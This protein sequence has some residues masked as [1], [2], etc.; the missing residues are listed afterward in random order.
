MGTYFLGSPCPIPTMPSPYSTHPHHAIPISTPTFQKKKKRERWPLMRC[1]PVQDVTQSCYM[2]YDRGGTT[3]CDANSI[4]N[5]MVWPMQ[6][7]TGNT[8]TNPYHPPSCN[9]L[10][11]CGGVLCHPPPPHCTMLPAVLYHLPPLYCA[12]LHTWHAS[13]FLH[14]VPSPST[15]IL[16]YPSRS[17]IILPSMLP[18]QM[19]FS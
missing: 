12:I 11:Q 6:R 5:R 14:T 15:P 1:E 8:Y 9:I 13:F 7:W 16:C 17:C 3:L 2:V 19:S 10:P 18:S 4:V